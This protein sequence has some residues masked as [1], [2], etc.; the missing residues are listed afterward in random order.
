[1]EKIL[2]EK[3]CNDV[4]DRLRSELADPHI[5]RSWVRRNARRFNVGAPDMSGYMRFDE[6]DI[7]M[8]KAI[9]CLSKMGAGQD[10]IARF[11]KYPAD[12]L[13][14]KLVYPYIKKAG[15][16]SAVFESSLSEAAFGGM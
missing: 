7:K 8:L 4:A 11:V 5:F 9:R 15:R 16:Y 10:I 13:S 2:S 12:P 14:W 6:D 3:V 1:M